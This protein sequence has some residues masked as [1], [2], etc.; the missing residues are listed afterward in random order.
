[1]RFKKEIAEE[2]S[3]L[4]IGEGRQLTDIVFL[5]EKSKRYADQ[6]K[7]VVFRGRLG[8]TK[9]F[10]FFVNEFLK[11]CVNLE[12]LMFV[13]TNLGDLMRNSKNVNV[14]RDLK[15]TKL[16]YVNLAQTDLKNNLVERIVLALKPVRT[17]QKINIAENPEIEL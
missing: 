9:D 10:A 8:A 17:M 13:N 16:Q 2:K 4:Y 3:V 1:M 6:I 7:S 14:F 5:I 15:G 12:S 11:E